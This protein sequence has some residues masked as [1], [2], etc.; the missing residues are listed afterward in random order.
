MTA[1][2]KR[3][4]EAGA[5]TPPLALRA[6]RAP[7][8]LDARPRDREA[9]TASAARARSRGVGPVEALEDALEM[10]RANPLSRIRDRELDPTF[11][12]SGRDLDATP[13]LWGAWGKGGPGPPPRGA[14]VRR[15]RGAVDRTA[16]PRPATP[17][18]GR[19]RGGRGA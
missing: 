18:A 3:D 12:G 4:D 2:R 16:A 1:P 7:V 9:D 10:L 6:D 19:R 17:S 13:P 11:G 15:L 8:R 14:G 5:R